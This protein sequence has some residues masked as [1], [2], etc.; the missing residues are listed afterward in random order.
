MVLRQF[1]FVVCRIVAVAGET[2]QLPH[3]YDLEFMCVAVPY[4][5]LKLRTVICFG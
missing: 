2:V 5:L 1:S 4:H 3:Q